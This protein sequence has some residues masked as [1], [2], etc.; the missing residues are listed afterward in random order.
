MVHQTI[1]VMDD[2]ADCVAG[3]GNHWD[4]ASLGLCK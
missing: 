4:G 1:G 2:R 3:A